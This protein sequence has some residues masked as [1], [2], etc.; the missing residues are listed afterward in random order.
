MFQVDSA[1]SVLA[2]EIDASVELDE[3]CWQKLHSLKD[4]LLVKI[5]VNEMPKVDLVFGRF[6]RA[7]N[8]VLLGRAGD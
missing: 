2:K 6:Q 7:T 8:I 1:D 5:N 3:S 4:H